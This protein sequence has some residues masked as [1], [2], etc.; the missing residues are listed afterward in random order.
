MV[1]ADLVGLYP[2]IFH[3]AG[4]KALEKA[5]NNCV[6]I[7]VSKE[8]LVK[9]ANFVLKNNYF[10]F[11]GKSK[12]QNKFAQ[13][14]TCILMDEF[15]ISFLEIQQMKPLILFQYID[16]VFFIWIHRLEKLDSFLEELNSCN[17]YLKFAYESSKKSIP[18]LNLKG[19]LSNR[20]L[21]TD[22]YIKLTDRHHFLHY[23]SFYP[24]HTKYSII[25]SQAMKI[26]RRYSDKSK[27]L[28]NFD[29]IKSRFNIRGCI[30]Y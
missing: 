10:K 24:D 9:M 2:S 5:L 28:K 8:H 12:Q 27:F 19:S 7:K 1:T 11:N 25:Y 29:K 14:Y 4:L 23:T 18:F 21:F 20:D 6:N 26:S 16:D 30:F 15:E 22:L 13:P 3:D 17:S